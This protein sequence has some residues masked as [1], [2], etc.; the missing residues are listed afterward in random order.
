MRQSLNTLITPNVIKHNA[1]G[2]S[3]EQIS[4]PLVIISELIASGSHKP[5]SHMK[6]VQPRGEIR[7]ELIKQSRLG[8]KLR[9]PCGQGKDRRGGLVGMTSIHERPAS[10]QT[11]EPFGDWEGDL[12]KGAGNASA[13][14]TLVERKSRFTVLVKMKD[15]GANAALDGF[16]RALDRI[17]Q[18]MR[19]SLAYDQ[20][21]E[22]ARHAELSQRL[23]M[24]VYFCD[25][26]SP[27]QRQT[28]T[29]MAWCDNI[30]P[31]V[32]T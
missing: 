32:S 14:G 25:Q 19:T 17:P 30:Y 20:G 6:L 31:R 4:G 15:C 7:H 3:P 5:I 28:R 2:W 10:V 27:W 9:H 12:I 18:Q 8:K 16:Q 13:I 26:L 22:M 21:K 23:K 24:K 29:P 11:R 1:K